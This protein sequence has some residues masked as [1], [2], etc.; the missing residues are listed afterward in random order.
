MSLFSSIQMASNSLAANAI[1]L[2]VVGQNISNANT[3][4]YIREEVVLSPAPTQRYGGLLLGMGVRVE[5]VVQKMDTFLEQ[6]LRNAISEE[7]SSGTLEQ[8]YNDLEK[9]IGELDETDLST[10]LDDF[11]NSVSEILNQ[12]ENISVRHLAVLNGETLATDIN[13][14]AGEVGELRA[15]VNDRV[16]LVANNINDLVETIRVLNIRIAETE[17]GNIS[18]SDAVGLRDQR[19][20]ALSSLAQLI[21]IRVVEGESGAVAVYTGGDYLVIDGISRHVAV[22][23]STDRGLAVA[24]VVIDEIDSRLNPSAGELQ[25]L[26]VSRDEVLAKFTDDLDDFSRTLAFEFN[27]LYSSGQGINGFDS[28]TSTEQVDQTDVALDQAGLGF[29]PVN[30][31]FRVLVHN[32]NTGLSETTNVTVDL[33]GLDHDTTLEDLADALNAIDGIAAEITVGRSL[34]ITST[35]PNQVFA[36]SDDTS[37]LLAALG[38]NTFFSGDTALGLSV[39]SV[40]KEDPAKFAASRGGIGADTDNAVEL[41]AF[42]DRPLDSQ[43][44]VSLSVLYDRFVADTTQGATIASS[45]AAG[46]RV[47]STSLEGQKMALSGVN[48][49]EEAVRMMAFQRAFQASSKYIVTLD[50]LFQLLVTL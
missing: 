30:G 8:T 41:A 16:S 20:E 34:K 7:T 17:G 33:N 44:G 38:M 23:M 15:D 47:F 5:A 48:L 12:P 3:P 4:G 19:L 28:L 18:A 32:K 50:E 37:G 39:N 42:L 2:Q 10:S 21:D 24:N 25:G 40:L 9:L 26:L 36:F 43:N 11:F 29:T 49:D 46:A 45:V 13:R 1:A 14:L 6:R 27:K 35:D 22:E 31:S